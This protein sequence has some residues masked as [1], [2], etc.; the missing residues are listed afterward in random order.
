MIGVCTKRESTKLASFVERHFMSQL[1]GRGMAV[2]GIV[3][4]FADTSQKE[5]LRGI[6]ERRCHL[7]GVALL[8]LF[9][10]WLL[11]RARSPGIRGKGLIRQETREM[12]I[13]WGRKLEYMRDTTGLGFDWELLKNVITVFDLCNQATDYFGWALYRKW[14]SSDERSHILIKKLVKSEFLIFNKGKNEY[15]A[16]KK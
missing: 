15:Y 13:G 7:K 12:E 5:E 10:K 14:E 2:A 16:Y 1:G 4:G 8:D 9:P 3:L 11:K 6:W